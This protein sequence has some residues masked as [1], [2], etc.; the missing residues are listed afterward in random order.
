MKTKPSARPST[1]RWVPI[2]AFLVTVLVTAI[3]IPPS[4]A[5]AG[6]V[7]N[8]SLE[9]DADSNGVP[10][11]FTPGGWGT[12]TATFT[13]VADAHTGSWGER[14]AITSYT[15]GDRK[16][17]PTMAAGCAP[18]ATPGERY[19]ASA[20]YHATVP[21]AFVVYALRPT[22]WAYWFDGAV[23]PPAPTFQ[24]ASE[25][26]PPIPADVS[27]VSFGL[28]IYAVGEIVTDDYGLADT[29]TAPACAAGYVALTYDDGPGPLTPTLL[30]TL[31]DR[32][33]RATFFVVGDQISTAREAVVRRERAE[34]HVVGNHTWSHARLTDLSSTQVRSEFTRLNDRLVALGLPRP[35][36]WRPPYSAFDSRIDTIAGN[37]GMTRTLFDVNTGDADEPGGVSVEETTRRAVEGA[38]AGSI[39]IMHDQ[40]ANSVAA[41]PGIIDGLRARGFCLGVVRPSPVFDP[42]TQ[43]FVAVVP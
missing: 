21:V 34:G 43:S 29:G 19:T 22:G 17:V 12:S 40:K 11:C 15:S 42:Q 26:L 35:T 5:T 8:P 10:D 2:V 33:A 1:G 13:R 28:A 6:P 38:R 20:W 9:S 41:T 23:R 25:D 4:G 27:A 3:G 31:A 14:L 39:V 32:H 18:T 7:A 24:R 36:L 37:L 30:D 16:L